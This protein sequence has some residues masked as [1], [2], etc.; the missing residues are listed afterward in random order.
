[1]AKRR[2]VLQ[3]LSE[4]HDAYHIIIIFAT[5]PSIS[6]YFLLSPPNPTGE[7]PYGNPNA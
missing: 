4:E 1:M 3:K 7:S 2:V 6:S 5:Q